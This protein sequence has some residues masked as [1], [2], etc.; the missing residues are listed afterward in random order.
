M[1]N[2]TRRG[3][4]RLSSS[5]P[6]MGWTV[7]VLHWQCRTCYSYKLLLAFC[8]VGC[9]RAGLTQYSLHM[10]LTSPA[11]LTAN[12]I[13]HGL[14]FRNSAGDPNQICVVLRL[15]YAASQS[16]SR[17]WSRLPGIVDTKWSWI[18]LVV[19]SA[20]FHLL[21]TDSNKM[22]RKIFSQSTSNMRER[23]WHR[24]GHKLVQPTGIIVTRLEKCSWFHWM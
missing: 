13:N 23:Y 9:L 16:W 7:P 22:T 11:S 24:R 5:V 2:M 3:F 15:L 6:T 20:A 8:T 18:I 1:I 4:V 10:S 12:I 21:Q 19:S 17:G 14:G